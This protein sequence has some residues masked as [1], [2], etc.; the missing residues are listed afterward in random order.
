MR[1]A[2]LN[3]KSTPRTARLA[4]GLTPSLLLALLLWGGLAS[5]RATAQDAA[6]PPV[7]GQPATLPARVVRVAL[8]IVGNDDR[9]LQ[10][11]LQRAVT[12]LTE[13]PSV[14]GRRPV[15]VVELRPT[16]AGEGRGAGTAF[17]RAVSIA[18]FLVS[19]ELAAV[20]TVAYIPQSLEGHGVLVALA[21][22]EIAIDPTA[23]FGRAGADEDPAKPIEPGV[24]ALYRQISEQR[25]TAPVALALGM[26]DPRLEVLRVETEGGV[27]FVTRAEL[28]TLSEEQTVVDEQVL[29]P[30]G[31]LGVLTGREA[32]ELGVARYLA[33]D[34]ATLARVLGAAEA[35]VSEDLS[36]VAEW[37]PV[38]VDLA[39]PLTPA[40][41]KRTQTLLGEEIARGSNWIGLRIDSPGGDWR[42]SLQLARTVADLRE[43][44]A[45]VVAYVPNEAG[46]GA[47][48]VALACDQIVMHPGARLTGVARV[49]E[50]VPDPAGDE[51]ADGGRNLK[52]EAADDEPADAVAANEAAADPPLGRAEL[53]SIVTT[54][55]ES[56]AERTGRTW[57]LL[58]SVVDPALEVRRYSHNI[59]GA[60]RDFCPEELAEQPNPDDWR[61]GEVVTE[62]GEPLAL[63]AE[64]AERLGVAWAVVDSV[65]GLARLYGLESAPRTA[66]PNWALELVEALA[67][68]GFAALLLVAAIAGI[69]LELNTP[70][71]GIG[72]FISAVAFML[73]FWSKF[74]HGT[75]DWLEA[76]LF[77]V[78]LMF[79]L[80]EI[81]VLPGFGIFGLGGGAMV[82]AA[83]VLASQTFIL[84]QTESQLDQLRDSLSV[85]AGSAVGCLVV[86]LALR[87]YLPH[88][89]VFQRLTLAGGEEADRIEQERRE[90]IADY[91]HLVGQRGEAT[92]SLLPSGKAEI[93]GELVDVM[94]DGGA[95]DRGAR[96]EVVKVQGTRVLVRQV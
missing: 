25:R 91:T 46:A 59:N 90:A 93:D 27:E 44:E 80:V 96:V 26:V 89:P 33:P 32:R 9:T 86:G 51:N 16:E 45:R 19:D 95:I 78:G 63:D 72:G 31:S 2:P 3:T 48:L 62:A 30:A 42:N 13:S 68:P 28:Q 65:D 85:V 17:E 61:V 71:L 49:A 39:G 34:R 60:Q 58:S 77:I 24:A 43:A 50:E 84:P 18:R 52:R 64:R 10:G 6:E 55:R 47:A 23:E 94:A 11:R 15:L 53:E 83:L 74:L 22:E 54:L 87:K 66:E 8:P 37:R 36:L 12:Q 70:G 40:V 29:V 81:F 21:C 7:A 69:Y 57:S 67:S 75:A 76:L 56:L 79:I 88:S 35:D 5:G 73:F 92:T 82:I 38:M 1:L 4:W 14:D 20:R 41:V